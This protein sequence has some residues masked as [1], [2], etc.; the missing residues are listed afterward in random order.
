MQVMKC[1]ACDHARVRD[2]HGKF[3]GRSRFTRGLCTVCYPRAR[4]AGTLEEIA[5]PPNQSSQGLPIGSRAV[6]PG[7]YVEIKTT[8]GFRGEHRIVM[9]EQLGRPLANGENVHHINGIRDDNRIENLE[10]W[11]TSQPKGQRVRQLIEYIAEFH[12]EAMRT[13]LEQDERAKL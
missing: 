3:S 13:A 6:T 8:T 7:G 1:L 10:L 9:E 11:A 12:P 5:L 2:K 4:K